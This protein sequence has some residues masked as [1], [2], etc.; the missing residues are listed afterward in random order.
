MYQQFNRYKILR[1]FFDEPNIKF[2]LRELERKTGISL[3][4]II[5]HVESLMENGFLQEVEG[6]VYKGYKSSMNMI[7]RI[8][9]RNDLLVRLEE[10]GL[11]KEIEER[12]TPNCIV[13]YGSGVEGRDDERGDIDI[14]V[15]SK[16]KRIE[17]EKYENELKRKISLLFEPGIE[18]I[19]DK[20]KNT[21]ANG[22]VLSGF[23]GVV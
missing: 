16:E 22:V 8:F 3:P 18:R 19:D 4:S 12:C 10:C 20:L 23:L 7:Y 2:Q 11:L 15:Q 6:G 9:K 14:F 1:V 5:Q 13:L 21:L 17:L